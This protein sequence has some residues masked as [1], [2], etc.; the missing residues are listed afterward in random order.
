MANKEHWLLLKQGIKTVWNNWRT[1]NP[2]VK[3]DLS[4]VDLSNINLQGVNFTSVDLSGANLSRA[5]LSRA[6][7]SEANL[8]DANLSQANLS[9]ANF[10]GVYLSGAHLTGVN[11]SRANLR[12]TDL[13]DANLSDANLP[14]VDLRWADISKVNFSGANLSG[15]NL[16][17]SNLRGANLI[18]ANLSEADFN[19]ADLSEADLSEA[20]LHKAN[21]IRIQALGTNFTAATLTGTCLENWNINSTTNLTDVI[22]DYIYL[23]EGQQERRPSDIKKN[24]APRELTTLVQKYQE[25]VDLMFEDGIEWKAFLLSL[26]ELKTEYGEENLSI[27]AFE[28]RSGET[29]VIR[30]E[31]PSSVNKAEI[32]RQAKNLYKSQ[33]N[34][35]EERNSV[36]LKAQDEQIGIHRQH[37][38]NLETIIHVLANSLS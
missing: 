27:Q 6:D 38:T 33:L 1:E 7:L 25:T 13:R 36:E 24:F 10:S 34:L 20:N 32:E 9:G 15:A 11:L 8:S 29:F 19:S 16:S 30:L 5:D 37:N 2:E 28:K 12:W 18:K 26:Q 4:G 23:R 3:P 31:I 22:C 17:G 14:S 21:L 35:I